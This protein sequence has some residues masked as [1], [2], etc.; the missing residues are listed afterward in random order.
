MHYLPKI[1]AVLLLS[2]VFSLSYSK[3]LASKLYLSPAAGSQTT[4]FSVDVYLD[5][6]TDKV[7][8][9]DAV[10]TYDT[11]KLSITEI[12]NGSMEQYLKKTFNEALG[13]IEISA[14]NAST[15]VSIITKIATIKFKPVGSGIANVKFLFTP[16][17]VSDSNAFDKGVESLTSVTD[18]TYTVTA[19]GSIGSVVSQ[20]PVSGG[21]LLE[22]SPGGKV[23]ST[24][25]ADNTY[26]LYALIS[27][28][29][30]FSG[31]FLWRKV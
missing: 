5:P 21:G 12:T 9:V 24:G 11:S 19:F 7:D 28:S 10:L 15:S 31:L 3:A 25:Y 18:G 1:L 22:S 20:M 4:D 6:E 29:L 13:K 23:P 26:L 2:C 8:A 14:L 17:D 27:I 30:I 16:G